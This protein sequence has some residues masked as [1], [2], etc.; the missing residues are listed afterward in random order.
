MEEL[1]EVLGINLSTAYRKTNG[2]RPITASEIIHVCNAFST[3]E[4]IRVLAS[5]VGYRLV[6]VEGDPT[7]IE[8]NVLMVKVAQLTKETG[9]VAS[10]V[11]KAAEDHVIDTAEA[12][13]LRK[14]LSDVGEIVN[15][16]IA[17]IDE[18]LNPKAQRKAS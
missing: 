3:H 1:A 11:L 17:A 14:E 2:E 4:P 13:R 7:D 16:L 15:V 10:E 9:E 18:R 12:V 6:P 8:P 5:R